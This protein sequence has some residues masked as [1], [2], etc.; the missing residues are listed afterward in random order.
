M[1]IRALY[2]Q[3]FSFL[4]AKLKRRPG[5]STKRLALHW[6]MLDE[7]A[8]RTF[9]GFM[10]LLDP[11]VHWDACW[12]IAEKY[13]KEY[14]DESCSEWVVDNPSVALVATVRRA[15]SHDF[16]FAWAYLDVDVTCQASGD[17]LQ[18]LALTL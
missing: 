13:Y 17:K 7:E 1:P 16:A 5:D 14:F 3:W 6:G 9:Y 12:Y 11:K 4:L 2:E 8:R 10:T 15:F 18:R